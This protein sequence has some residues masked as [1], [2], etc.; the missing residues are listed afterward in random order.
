MIE[1][2]RISDPVSIQILSDALESRQILFRIDNAGMNALMPLPTV[3]DARVLVAE[4]DI[5][6]AE[7][8]LSDLELN[9]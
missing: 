9:L 3:M 7:L 2:I 5:V 1:L 6:A 4:E 8:I